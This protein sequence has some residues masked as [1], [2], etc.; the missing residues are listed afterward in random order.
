MQKFKEKLKNTPK[1]AHQVLCSVNHQLNREETL[2]EDG[3]VRSL[4]NPD[5][6]HFQ[7]TESSLKALVYVISKEGNPLMPCTYAKAIRMLK[8]GA[9]SVIK[10]IPFTIQ[11]NF[12]CENKVQEIILGVDTGYKNIGI[13]A[14]SNSKELLSVNVELR[15]DISEKLKERAMYRRN[16]RNKLWY[17]EPRWNNRA[18]AKQK[19]RLMPS[20]LQKVNTHITIIERIKKILPISKIIIE[21]GL[22][23]MAKMNDDGIRNW[24]YAKGVQYG[25]ENTKA[26]VLSRDSHKC[27]FNDKCSDK[28]HVHHIKFRK[29]GG[30]DNPNNLITLCEKHHKQLHD[31]KI[32]LDKV[33]KFKELKAATVMNIIRKSLLKYFPEAIETF[34]YETKVKSRELGIEKSHINDAF[35]I[36]GGSIQDR[37][38]SFTMIQKRKN[39][40]CLQLNRKG[41]KPSIKKQRSKIQ[42]LD[43]FWVKGKEYVCKGMFNY[44]K[45]ICYGSTKLKEYFKIELVEKHYYQGSLVW[46]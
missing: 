30:S 19:G 25:F 36:A 4:N 33:G 6:D 15:I 12:F 24:E 17:R 16:R 3:I 34:G 28:L 9:A 5:G 42:P 18:N 39:N 1:D 43:L 20:V 29:D 26:Y 32:K 14:V 13:S 37:S 35:V 22:F 44:G 7:H 23:D 46:N 21:T 8:K 2:S 10:R 40:R 38:K 45:Y 27:Y 31:G 11:L 41:F